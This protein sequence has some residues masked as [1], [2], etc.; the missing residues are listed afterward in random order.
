MRGRA[1]IHL[2]GEHLLRQRRGMGEEIAHIRAVAGAGGD[3]A[4]QRQQRQPDA[5]RFMAHRPR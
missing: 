5:E 4:A 3:E 1:A 2:A